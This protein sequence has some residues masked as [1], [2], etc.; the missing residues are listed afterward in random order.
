MSDQTILFFLAVFVIILILVIIYQRIAFGR[1]T[2][3]KLK[4][5][6]GKIEEI[7]ETDS[8]EKVDRKS[9]V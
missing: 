4:Q 9:V 7:L 5:I 8:D 1:G 3:A 6:N 2:Q